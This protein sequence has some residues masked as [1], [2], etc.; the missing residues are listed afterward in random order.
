MK[1]PNRRGA[2]GTR[3][4]QHESSAQEP[5]ESDFTD[6]VERA[7]RRRESVTDGD[8]EVDADGTVRQKPHGNMDATLVPRGKEHPEQGPYVPEH[9]RVD[10]DVDPDVEPDRRNVSGSR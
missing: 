4:A 1:T 8:V 6:P 3:D 9:D 10:P 5:Y 7:D 2:A